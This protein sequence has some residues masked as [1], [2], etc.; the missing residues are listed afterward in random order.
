MPAAFFAGAGNASARR[1]FLPLGS[2]TNNGK[3]PNRKETEMKKLLATAATLSLLAAPAFAQSQTGTADQPDA[4]MTQPAEGNAPLMSTDDMAA[5]QDKVKKILEEAGMTDIEFMSAAFIVEGVS[6]EDEHVILMVD[7]NGRVLGAQKAPSPEAT[8][9][10]SND[11]GAATS[12]DSDSDMDDTG[13]D[14]ADDTSAN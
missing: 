10:T 6:P 9:S 3:K 7:T 5:S 12:D 1:V 13:T 11:S 2:R 8:S 4:G 14:G